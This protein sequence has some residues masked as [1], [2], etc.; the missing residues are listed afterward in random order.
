MPRRRE[1]IRSMRTLG[2]L[3]TLSWALSAADI[4]TIHFPSQDGK[5]SLVGYVFEPAGSGPHAAIVMLHGR[6]GPYSSL[7]NGLYDATTLSKRHKQWGEF[8]AKRGYAALL[9]DS[10]GPR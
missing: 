9:V 8:W 2:L 1:T 6:A 4:K 7:A 10:F 5:T 3:L